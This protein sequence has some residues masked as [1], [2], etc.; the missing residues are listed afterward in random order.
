MEALQKVTKPVIYL[1]LMSLCLYLAQ[2]LQSVTFGVTAITLLFL[3]VWLFVAFAFGLNF[4]VSVLFSTLFL[5]KPFESTFYAVLAILLFSVLIEYYQGRRKLLWPYP[6]ASA[7][8]IGTA[9]Y[10]LIR[11]GT[12]N[13]AMPY[14]FS[15]AIV[16]TV[17]L[18]C[19]ANSKV[20]AKLF[21]LWVRIIAGI[22]IFLAF[23]GVIVAILN[24]GKRIGSLWVTAMTI[25]GFYLLGMF[26]AIALGMKEKDKRKSILWYLGA[27]II[28]LGMVYTYTRMALLAVFFG[29]FLMMFK[30]KRFRLIGILIL[31]MIPL[32]IP[33][34][35]IERVQQT[36]SFDLSIF[37]RLLAWYHALRQISLHPFFGIGISTW[38]TWYLGVIPF[39]FLYAEHPHNLFLR[40]FVEIGV[41][42]F[43]S[44][45]WII[46]C[47]MRDFRK[48][49]VK[50]S[51]DQFYSVIYVGMLSLLFACLTDVFIQQYDLSMAFWTCIGFMYALSRKPIAE[52]EDT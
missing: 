31:L 41:F 45:F 3:G 37:I 17:M 23:I 30:M 25:N 24:P 43:I 34:S 48:R 6:W 13:F 11:S 39:T 26:F 35:M 22:N 47:V 51:R 8:L 29:F 5:V 28:F 21:D 52:K 40:V 19:F 33:A 46:F 7:I 27:L 18:V 44:Y 2:A 4:R 32:I 1:A 12:P 36:F 38:Q 50:P 14:F 9:I 49:V 20:D 42:G 16:P 15:T 10:G